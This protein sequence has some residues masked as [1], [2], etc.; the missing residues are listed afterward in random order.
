MNLSRR[1]S[2]E[3]QLK[4][5]WRWMCQV[6]AWLQWY[7][8]ICEIRLRVGGRPRDIS[9]HIC[10]SRLG[11]IG[12]LICRRASLKWSYGFPEE[13]NR[14]HESESV[15]RYSPSSHLSYLTGSRLSDAKT[16]VVSPH[17]NCKICR[18]L[19]Y[20]LVVTKIYSSGICHRVA[21][22]KDSITSPA[23]NVAQSQIYTSINVSTSRST[24]KCRNAFSQ[25][26][27]SYLD[28]RRYFEIQAWRDA[29]EFLLY[30]YLILFSTFSQGIWYFYSG[31][32]TDED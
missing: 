27:K 19:A 11:K 9:V 3:N 6:S 26:R 17:I 13:V 20:A 14:S 32:N 1:E 28:I 4:C 5:T 2:T 10:G 16:N 21:C 7:A 25:L 8:R 23:S 12:Y 15:Q 22:I 24:A 31:L 29:K 30:F 18:D